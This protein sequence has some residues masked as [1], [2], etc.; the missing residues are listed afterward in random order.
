MTIPYLTTPKPRYQQTAVLGKTLWI[1]KTHKDNGNS[2]CWSCAVAM[3]F[4]LGHRYCNCG[5]PANGYILRGGDLP[6]DFYCSDHYDGAVKATCQ[7]K[8]DSED[9]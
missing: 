9:D 7:P 3:I 8:L 1:C 4:N 6:V 5:E 2:V